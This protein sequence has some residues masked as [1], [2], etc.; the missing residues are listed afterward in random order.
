MAWILSGFPDEACADIAGQ[1]KVVQN[2]RLSHTDLR[3]VDGG[4]IVDVPVER[5]KV[6]KAQLDEAG[7]GVNMF[8]TPIGKIDLADDF[9]IDIDRLNHV[10][11]L[12]DVFGCRA[13]RV[14]SYYNQA[15]A[16]FV[17]WGKESLRR[18][19][20]LKARATDL[21]LVLYN[22]NERHLF[23][24]RADEIIVINDALRD[25]VTFKAIFDFDNYNQSGDDVWENWLK[26][27]DATDAF[28][29]KESDK[30]GQHVPM[31]E[32]AGYAREILADARERGWE[33]PLSLEPHLA[34]SP[35][36]MATGPSGQSNQKLADLAP[37]ECWAFAADV[38]RK[39]LADIH[40]PVA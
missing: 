17:A 4:N 27:R 13:V 36:V 3:G 38:A 39:L 16:P 15:N 35:A 24:D 37:T 19:G 31:G 33:G 9:Q 10:A 14:F 25:G 7:L 32:G 18:L 22:E 5:A 26:L 28:H 30:T 11:E 34:H 1:I 23:G 20:E 12:A 2:A 8:G 21:G 29:L 6:I 40:A